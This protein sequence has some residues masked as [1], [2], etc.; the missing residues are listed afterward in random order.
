MVEY[1]SITAVL[2]VLVSA[3]GGTLSLPA[4]NL[5]GTALVATLAGNQ[6][7]RG[8]EARA[9]YA[10]APF[11]RPALRYL[12]VVGWGDGCKGSNGVPGRS[13]ARP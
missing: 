13:A 3:I 10:R 6:G 2:A 7:V 4:T 9:A 12:Y 8:A 5:K 1:A 11:R